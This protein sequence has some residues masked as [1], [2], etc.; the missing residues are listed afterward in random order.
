MHS[1]VKLSLITE[2]KYFRDCQEALDKGIVCSGVYTI[3]PDHL[4]PFEASQIHNNIALYTLSSCTLLSFTCT[5]SLLS[6]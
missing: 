4:P 2:V 3:K 1:M 6:H 5:N